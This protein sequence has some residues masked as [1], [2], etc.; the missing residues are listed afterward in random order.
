MKSRTDSTKTTFTSEATLQDVS[1][2]VKAEVQFGSP[3]KNCTG[4]G[5][6]RVAALSASTARKKSKNSEKRSMAKLSLTKEKAIRISF[7][8]GTISPTIRKIYFHNMKF[9]VQD[10]FILPNAISKRLGV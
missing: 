1:K 7:M 2:T 9:I 10:E 6:C 8:K 4:V 5:I 3:Q